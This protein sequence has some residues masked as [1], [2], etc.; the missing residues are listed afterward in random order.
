MVHKNGPL[1][2]ES[3][4]TN[5]NFGQNQFQ[6]HLK[7][8]LL[9]SREDLKS[10]PSTQYCKQLNTHSY[11]LLI[12]YLSIPF[13]TQCLNPPTQALQSHCQQRWVNP[14]TGSSIHFFLNSNE[15]WWELLD[16]CSKTM[17]SFF[18]WWVWFYRYLL[19][20]SKQFWYTHTKSH[21]IQILDS[22]SCANQ[23]DGKNKQFWF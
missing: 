8:E 11:P 22:D 14:Y 13:L 1:E 18:S 21:P 2:S 16:I 15:I 23:M 9:C 5:S 7:S 6:F 12:R 17:F 19:Q 10:R 3:E 4:F 20:F